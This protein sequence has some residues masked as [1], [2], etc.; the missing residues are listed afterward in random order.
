MGGNQYGNTRARVRERVGEIISINKIK[1]PHDHRVR[2][3]DPIANS[4]ANLNCLCMNIP[5]D[6]DKWIKSIRALLPD[7]NNI[8][9]HIQRQMNMD[10][11][12]EQAK[13]AYKF[14][15]TQEPLMSIPVLC[16][17]RCTVTFTK[18][19]VHVNKDRKNINR[20]QRTIH[21]TVE[22]STSWKHPTIRTTGRTTNQCNYTRCNHGWYPQL[23]TSKH[24]YS[25]KEHAPERHTEK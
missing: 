10:E 9:A 8:N 18:H 22:I 2:N 24:E 7:G 13:T 6:Y 12:P 19:S 23:L 11:L 16:D 20:L 21:Q 4:G 5:R 15:N 17:N 1:I 14:N 25:N 3:L